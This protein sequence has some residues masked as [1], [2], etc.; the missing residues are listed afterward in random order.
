MAKGPTMQN[1]FFTCRRKADEVMCVAVR[2]KHGM[3][4]V[5]HPEGE[6]GYL[7][8]DHFWLNYTSAAATIVGPVG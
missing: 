7:D 8:D 4:S 3:W 5:L 2:D 1:E 6:H